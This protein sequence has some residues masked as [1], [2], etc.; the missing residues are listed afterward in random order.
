MQSISAQEGVGG[1]LLLQ[2]RI[3][4]TKIQRNAKAR[5]KKTT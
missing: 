4:M 3:R 1:R 2:F 5:R